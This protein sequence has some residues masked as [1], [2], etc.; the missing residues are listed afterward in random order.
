MTP[1]DQKR[2]QASVR[3]RLLNIAHRDSVD[4]QLILTR[5]ALKR[6]LFRLGVPPTGPSFS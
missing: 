1:G 2:L 6:L 5:Y 3:Q 4:F